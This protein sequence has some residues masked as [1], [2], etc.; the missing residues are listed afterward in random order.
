MGDWKRSLLNESMTKTLRPMQGAGITNFGRNG[1]GLRG[2][3]ASQ[4]HFRTGETS[5]EQKYIS[6]IEKGTAAQK[7]LLRCLESMEEVWIL[8]SEDT[9]K[10]KGTE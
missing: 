8:R 4:V 6:C 3:G 10:L 5:M 2:G 1:E 9:W 7:T